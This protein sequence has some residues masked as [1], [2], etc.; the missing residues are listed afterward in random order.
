MTIKTNAEPTD[1]EKELS[2]AINPDAGK[3]DDNAGADAAEGGNKDNEAAGKVDD[4]E[5]DLSKFGLGKV[6]KSEIETWKKSGM[7]EGDYRKKTEELSAREKQ[8]EDLVQ[9]SDYL[10]KQPKKLAK[11][12]AVLQE[13]EE[14]AEAA[15]DG[16]GTNKEAKDKAAQAKN[17]IAAILEKLDPEDP[18]AALLKAMYSQM[19]EIQKSI[20]GFEERETQIR[21]KEQQ[22]EQSKNLTY[23]RG[24]LTKTLD[25][26]LKEH[27]FDDDESKGLW[28]SLTL[29]IVK[30]NPKEYVN[31]E[32]FV[33]AIK[34]AGEQA[35][36]K[37]KALSDAALKKH[38]KSGGPKLPGAGGSGAAKKP[39]ASFDNLQALLEE[40]LGKANDE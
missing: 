22:D 1:A 14:A 21:T 19:S 3:P 7:Q 34:G 31:E 39:D 18:G 10:S 35:A 24:V 13:A 9:L 6:K 28:R 36:K 26:T 4:P 11:V 27:G 20:R 40:E 15:E 12:L 23:A 32:A 5:I 33:K 16:T 17:D 25:E 2:E 29:S 37:I 30:D 8:V 38:L